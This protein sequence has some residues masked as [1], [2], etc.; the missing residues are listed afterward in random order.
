MLRELLDG[1]LFLNVGN[2]GWLVKGIP[3][4]LLI[5]K[6]YSDSELVS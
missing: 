2:L 6:I 1:L 3:L 5:I 4:R